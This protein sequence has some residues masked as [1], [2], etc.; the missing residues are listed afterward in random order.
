MDRLPPD[1]LQPVVE[2]RLS[3]DGWSYQGT[4]LEGCFPPE[5]EIELGQTVHLICTRTATAW[6]HRRAVQL[7]EEQRA[8][9]QA[10]AVLE[11]WS[12]EGPDPDP[13]LRKW[14]ARLAR[15]VLANPEA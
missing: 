12:A 5:V 15:A 13:G 8:Y 3:I 14:R 11:I 2:P 7:L 10:Y 1:L 6:N 9:A 4:P